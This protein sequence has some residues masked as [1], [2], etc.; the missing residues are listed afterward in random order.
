MRGD[1]RAAAGPSTHPPGTWGL[2]SLSNALRA[3]GLVLGLDGAGVA[4]VSGRAA[5]LL[6]SRT[7]LDVFWRE[8]RG[9]DAELDATLLALRRAADSWRTRQ[10]LP[11]PAPA[12]VMTEFS[13]AEAAKRLQCSPQGVRKAI[14]SGRLRARMSGDRYV[15]SEEDLTH[16]EA[17]RRAA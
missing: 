12:A 10:Q 9:T 17:N 6:M 8:N 14:A 11:L 4:V 2:A 5:A 16:F 1:P 7:G 15:I 13:T 3:E